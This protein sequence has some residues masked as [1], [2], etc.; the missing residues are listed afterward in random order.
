M[1][2]A[3]TVRPGFWDDPTVGR[4]SS[5]ARLLM[6]AT[7]TFADDEGL[8]RWDAPTLKENVF[9]MDPEVGVAN[10]HAMMGE[11]TSAGLIHPYTDRGTVFGFVV[12]FHQQ[13]KFNRP[14]PSKLPAPP[15]AD[16]GVATMYLRRDR[17][18]CASCQ[19]TISAP[20][21]DRTA[22]KTETGPGFDTW[23]DGVVGPLRRDL[24]GAGS[25]PSNVGSFH[26]IC[27]AGAG[28]QA[29]FEQDSDAGN[30]SAR[31][32]E[33]SHARLTE[34]SVSVSAHSDET[35]A[36]NTGPSAPTSAAAPTLTC[37]DTDSPVYSSPA[38]GRLTEPSH[39]ALTESSVSAHRGKGREGKGMEG[40]GNATAA[41]PPLPCPIFVHTSQDTSTTT[42][43]RRPSPAASPLSASS[44]PVDPSNDM[45]EDRGT[46]K[47]S[48][49]DKPGSRAVRADLNI[50]TPTATTPTTAAPDQPAATTADKNN[51]RNRASNRT[52]THTGEDHMEIEQDSL[53]GD[54][55]AFMPAPAPVKEPKKNYPATQLI[56][57]PWWS[58]FEGTQILPYARVMKT[59]LQALDSGITPAVVTAGMRVLGLERKPVT[60]G[61]LQ[62]AIGNLGK[63]AA[64]SNLHSH[65][66]AGRNREDGST[67]STSFY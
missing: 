61:T 49:D 5:A 34:D 56:M 21:G 62:V 10:V 52:A 51:T 43:S 23:A 59:V 14:T 28:F 26:A 30:T 39:A 27:R 53:F 4:L 57:K 64:S 47:A 41:P 13:Q 31:L 67:Y 16:V 66:V 37:N 22:V 9:E 6:L 38:S 58:Q 44:K 17:W 60:P 55:P 40:N 50:T 48:Q 29:G 63:P 54:D 8:L 35:A 15:L 3:R 19:K 45:S 20:N 33:G 11:L 65:E 42:A 7:Y 32:T 24:A 1:S 18:V 12:D 25:Y 46:T 2:R 36:V